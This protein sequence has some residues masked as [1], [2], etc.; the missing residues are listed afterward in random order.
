PEVR[1]RINDDYPSETDIQTLEAE[2]EKLKSVREKHGRLVQKLQKRNEMAAG[3]APQAEELDHLVAAYPDEKINVVQT[4]IKQNEIA[5]TT[6]EDRLKVLVSQI[7]QTGKLFNDAEQRV[8][9]LQEEIT[10]QEKAMAVAA[11]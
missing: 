6:L 1:R 2:A 9:N 10:A 3:R 7:G 11:E 8:Q 4:Q 5:V